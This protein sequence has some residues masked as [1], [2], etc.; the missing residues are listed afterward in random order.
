MNGPW[1]IIVAVV[2]SVF[3]SS[4]FWAFLIERQKKNSAE[5]RLLL[6]IGYY[7]I[8]FFADKYIDRGWITRQEYSDLKKYL[9]EPYV[10]R[11]GNGTAKR[12]MQEIDN[13]PIKEE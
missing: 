1:D 2:V 9:Y 11:G 4:G 3:A 10:A 6:G 7:E 8:C 5:Q 12:L 13:L